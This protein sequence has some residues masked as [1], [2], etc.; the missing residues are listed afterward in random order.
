MYDDTILVSEPNVSEKD[1]TFCAENSLLVNEC[2][3]SE[4]DETLSN[5]DIDLLY[6][7]PDL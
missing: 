1:D 5:D 7:F 3:A 4:L 2:F 6:F